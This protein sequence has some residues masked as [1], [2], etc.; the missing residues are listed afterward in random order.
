MH[1]GKNSPAERVRGKAIAKRLKVKKDVLIPEILPNHAEN[2]P[3]G[4]EK[5][6]KTAIFC[7]TI[8]RATK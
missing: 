2:I 8:K 5:T 3:G 7:L 1:T 4:P 6:S